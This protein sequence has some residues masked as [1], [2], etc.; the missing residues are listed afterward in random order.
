MATIED[1]LVRLG[2]TCTNNHN[3]TVYDLYMYMYASFH[4]MEYCVCR[5]IIVSSC[6][7]LYSHNCSTSCEVIG[8]IDIQCVTNV[9][10]M[11]HLYRQEG[12]SRRYDRYH[13]L[14][15]LLTEY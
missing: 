11:L 8:I 9:E 10:H 7:N 12:D 14:P 1:G 13:H 15:Y 2:C 4:N 3:F 6:N 5:C